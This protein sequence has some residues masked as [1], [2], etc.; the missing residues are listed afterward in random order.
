M[1]D[2]L[3]AKLNKTKQKKMEKTIGEYGEESDI[4]G[5]TKYLYKD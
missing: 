3:K 4:I 5:L 1:I 2:K